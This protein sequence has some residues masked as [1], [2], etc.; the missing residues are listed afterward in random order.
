M[1]RQRRDE[2]GELLTLSMEIGLLMPTWV[3][4]WP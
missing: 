3:R 1:V 4:W 2:S